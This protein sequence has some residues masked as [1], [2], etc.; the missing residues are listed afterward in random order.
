M[1][2]KEYIAK[3]Q[4]E[5][6]APKYH[7]HRIFYVY[8]KDGQFVAPFVFNAERTKVKDIMSEK[9]VDLKDVDNEKQALSELFSVDIN[10]IQYN[11]LLN[12]VCYCTYGAIIPG[13]IFKKVCAEIRENDHNR[14]DVIK[15]GSINKI[16]ASV[17]DIEPLTK[18]LRENFATL[19]EATIERDSVLSSV[20]ENI[21]F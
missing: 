10:K 4:Q 17:Y 5:K 19:Y 2:L 20:E 6:S 9:I 7:I 15:H 1:G 3:K 13:K 12:L 11:S 8:T 14:D 18:Q 16:I 21:N